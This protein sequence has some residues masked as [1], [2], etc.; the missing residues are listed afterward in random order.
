MKKW[1]Y[2]IFPSLML[3]VFIGFYISSQNELA[4]REKQKAEE[5]ARQKAAEDAHKAALEAKAAEDAARHTA[6]RAAEDAKALAEKEAKW[7]AESDRIQKET[8]ASNASLDKYSK[9]VDKLQIQLDYLHKA[10]EEAN[11][12][13]FESFKRVQLADVERRN[14][15]LEVQRMVAMISKRA[16]DSSLTKMPAPAP[17]PAAN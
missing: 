12:A 14:A 6:E 2:V 13:S 9:L 10:K 11:R 17:V 8:D 5:V 1:M 7:Q 16:E 15:E 4:V 3:L